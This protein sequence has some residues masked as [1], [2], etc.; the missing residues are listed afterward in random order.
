MDSMMEL[1]EAGGIPIYY[2][3]QMVFVEAGRG[4]DGYKGVSTGKGGRFYFIR[5]MVLGR[6]PLG[7]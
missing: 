6:S 7:A 2:K 5:L 1:V 4:V 3:E